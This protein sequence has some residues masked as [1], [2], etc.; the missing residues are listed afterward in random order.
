MNPIHESGFASLV[1]LFF[2]TAPSLL[3]SVIALVLAKYRPKGAAIA[4]GI[5]VML[6]GLV[7][8]LAAVTTSKLHARVDYWINTGGYGPPAEIMA[9]YGPDWHASARFTAMAGLLF[10]AFPFGL[11][12]LAYRIA[13]GK[14]AWSPPALGIV[15]FASVAWFWCLIMSIL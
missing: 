1:V 10:T 13:R 9:K 5:A 11:S 8:A 3:A 15:V 7:C 6:A 4:A 14:A 2:A 12:A